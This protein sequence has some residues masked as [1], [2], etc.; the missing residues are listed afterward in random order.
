MEHSVLVTFLTCL[1]TVF[2]NFTYFKI[3]FY[4]ALFTRQSEHMYAQRPE[5]G[6]G[7]WIWSYGGCELPDVG[8]GP[9]LPSSWL[10][11]S[12][13]VASFLILLPPQFPWHW[14]T[15]FSVAV[16]LV[17]KDQNPSFCCLYCG[18]VR[19][20]THVESSEIV[21]IC[22]SVTECTPAWNHLR[23]LP[24]FETLHTH[25]EF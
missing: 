2:F 5:G 8:P 23:S 22:G 1:S 3:Y 20:S 12:I 4:F 24:R 6:V 19:V 7:P 11:R 13:S 9:E 17:W 10:R 21:C 15:H 14:G 16:C 25:L 18:S